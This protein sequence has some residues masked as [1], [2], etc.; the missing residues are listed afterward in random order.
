M[1]IKRIIMEQYDEDSQ[2]NESAYQKPMEYEM[3]TRGQ[4][5]TDGATGTFWGALK[6]GAWMTLFLI[7]LF[8]I[9]CKLEC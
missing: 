3:P 8:S 9:L 2:H 4:S 1:S 5:F 7:I 6:F